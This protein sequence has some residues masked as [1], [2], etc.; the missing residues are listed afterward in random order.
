[1]EDPG[2][3]L[4][5]AAGL[6]KAAGR[7]PSF[8]SHY[9]LYSCGGVGEP[10]QLW[11]FSFLITLT[12]WD[13][14]L[15][16]WQGILNWPTSFLP[17]ALARSGGEGAVAWWSCGYCRPMTMTTGD[18]QASVRFVCVKGQG[19]AS[20]WPADLEQCNKRKW[21]VTGNT[22]AGRAEWGSPSMRKLMGWGDSE[23]TLGSAAHRGSQGRWVVEG[24]HVNTTVKT[25]PS[26]R[27][28]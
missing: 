2:L 22:D 28:A 1:M 14:D 19:T 9:Q 20:V 4:W 8:S 5:V 12:I 27:R 3:S 15:S 26:D 11:D 25:R 17:Q 13:L 6:N 10:H 16:W 18:L 23:P 7:F 24:Y 21:A